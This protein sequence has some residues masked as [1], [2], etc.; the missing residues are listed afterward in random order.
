MTDM[1]HLNPAA[2]AAAIL[3]PATIGFSE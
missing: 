1:Q 3:F 2:L